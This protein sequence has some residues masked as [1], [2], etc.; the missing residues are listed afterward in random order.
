MN[1]HQRNKVHYNNNNC[2]GQR[3]HSPSALLFS[4]L[5]VWW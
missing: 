3:L 5:V 4:F 1:Q 2:T